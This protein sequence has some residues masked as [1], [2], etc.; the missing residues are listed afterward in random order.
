MKEILEKLSAKVNLDE[1]EAYSA[2]LSIMT[3][4][5]HPH[6]LQDF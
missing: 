6:K 5:I 3:V 2:M 1:Q 4:N